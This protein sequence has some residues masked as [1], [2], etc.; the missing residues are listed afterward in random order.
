MIL[1]RTE[2]ASVPACLSRSKTTVSVLETV[3]PQH[4][5][6]YGVATEYCVRAEVLSMLARGRSVTVVRDAIKGIDPN[7]EAAA[8]DEM[9]RAGAAL[10][11]TNVVLAALE[12]GP[13]V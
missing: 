9:E 2:K 12:G 13:G 8:L 10:T 11:S 5:V 6:V 3:A 7:A 4:V 1:E